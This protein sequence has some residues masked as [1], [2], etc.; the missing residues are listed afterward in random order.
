[1]AIDWQVASLSFE[2]FPSLKRALILENVVVV[3]LV[4]YGLVVGCA[5]WSEKKSG[6]RLAKQYLLIRFFS[7]T[8]IDLVALLMIAD[9]PSTVIAVVIHEVVAQTIADGV[10]CL[11]W[12]LYF[13][14]SKRVRNTYGDDTP[15]FSG[16]FWKRQFG[17][18]R[19]VRPEK[20]TFEAGPLPQSKPEPLAVH[21]KGLTRDMNRT[22]KRILAV[23]VGIVCLGLLVVP[24]DRTR[25][26]GP[27]SL[28]YSIVFLLETYERIHFARMILPLIVVCII[29]A[30][31]IYLTR[32][33]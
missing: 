11:V 10:F 31:A 5:L 26:W 28:N 2:Q 23:G 21:E 33:R 9:L 22:Q 24:I 30:T 14:K 12:W 13:K 29:T 16:G 3:T 8:G 19:R 20:A 17:F 7:I 1:M 15:A 32:G 6:A 27:F 25:F 4:I 18:H